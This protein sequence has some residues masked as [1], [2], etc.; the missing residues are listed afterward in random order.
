MTLWAEHLTFGGHSLHNG[1]KIF[2]TSSGLAAVSGGRSS[3]PLLALGRGDR[4]EYW[5][6][7]GGDLQYPR[8]KL[9][10]QQ[11]FCHFLMEW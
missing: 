8:K 9:H 5:Q 11:N 2:F 6:A 1:P 10:H 4:P 3:P 7:G